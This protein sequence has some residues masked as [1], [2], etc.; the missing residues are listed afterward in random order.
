MSRP[1][2]AADLSLTV[3]LLATVLL[4]ATGGDTSADGDRPGSLSC[5]SC[6]ADDFGF[7]FHYHNR[8]A[9]P[10]PE[11]VGQDALGA[12]QEVVG[13][14]LADPATDWSEVSIARL[15]EHLVAMD[16][17][18]LRAEVAERPIDGGLEIELTG[19]ER[20]VDAIRRLVPSH[21]RAMDGFRGWRVAAEDSADGVRLTLEST[22]PGEA[23]VIR[24]LGFFGFMASGVHHP[25]ELLAVA[26]GR[27]EHWPPAS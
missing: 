1:P 18:M 16:E 17:V 8:P 20:T 15:R 14:L 23:E 7:R 12:V 26:R 11:L 19:G 24:A 22:D 9:R 13:L 6:G 4:V 2:R 10:V 27:S 25:H 5:P 21:A 3:A